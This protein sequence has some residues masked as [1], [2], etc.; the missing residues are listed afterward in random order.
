MTI[1]ALLAT[2]SCFAGEEKNSNKNHR[3]AVNISKPDFGV[4]INDDGDNSFQDPSASIS[5]RK[6]QADMMAIRQAG[7]KTITYS[8]GQGVLNYPSSI[9]SRIGWRN[10]GR[11]EEKIEHIKYGRANLADGFDPIRQ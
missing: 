6:L 1:L 9:G 3:Y 7:I 11:G 4:I 10:T 8:I 5:R 2:N